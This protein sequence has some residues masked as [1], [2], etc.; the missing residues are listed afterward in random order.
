MASRPSEDDLQDLI[1][2]RLP[3]RRLVE[4]H[5]WLAREPSL[6]VKARDLRANDLLLQ[7]YG[8]EMLSRLAADGQGPAVPARFRH[9]LP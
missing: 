5:A 4:V 8:R 3:E 1:D 7:R 2:G 9:L 6:A